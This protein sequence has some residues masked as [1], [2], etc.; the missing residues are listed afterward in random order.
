V[1]YSL[2]KFSVDDWL[3]M[4]TQPRQSVEHSIGASDPNLDVIADM[5]HSL[6]FKKDGKALVCAGI[7]PIWS[8][9]GAAWLILSDEVHHAEMRIV[10]AEVLKFLDNAPFRR[11]ETS[12]DS[13]F[14]Q[15]H[16]WA[17]ML[18]FKPEGEMKSYCPQGRDHWLYARV[19]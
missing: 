3:Q 12:V 8:G 18:G 1:G 14:R 19:K 15:A 4:T 6:T 13:E 10:H 17:I 7:I 2:E 16:R 5:E 9:R 11:I